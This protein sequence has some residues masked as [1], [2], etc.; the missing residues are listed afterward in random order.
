MIRLHYTLFFGILHFTRTDKQEYTGFYD[1]DWMGRT[2]Y[3]A[4]K[5][6]IKIDVRVLDGRR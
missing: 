3:N 5:L 4:E 2:V 1:L 6:N